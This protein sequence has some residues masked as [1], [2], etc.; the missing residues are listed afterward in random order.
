MNKMGEEY[1]L[2]NHP[3]VRYSKEFSVAGVI[4]ALISFGLMWKTDIFG[5]WI[6]GVISILWYG[7]FEFIYLYKKDHDE[8][9]SWQ[10]YRKLIIE[11]TKASLKEITAETFN[12]KSENDS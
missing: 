5:F 6:A 11:M 4:F 7:V 2:Q 3:L 9:L 1:F 8:E 12:T 10:A